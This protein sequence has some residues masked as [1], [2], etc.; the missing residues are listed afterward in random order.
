MPL[1]PE[2]IDNLR[3]VS[4]NLEYFNGSSW[5]QLNDQAGSPPPIGSIMIGM[6][7][8][9]PSNYLQ[10]NRATL[11][12]TTYSELWDYA[13]NNDLLASGTNPA[14]SEGNIIQFIDV[15]SSNFKL[16]DFRGLNPVV[17]GVNS[18]LQAGNGAS[19]QAGMAAYQKWM[20]QGHRHTI[21]LYTPVGS[22]D[23][24]A[25]STGS[26]GVGI[27]NMQYSD[28]II[29]DTVNGT[30]QVGGYTRGPGFGIGAYI[31][32]Q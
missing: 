19:L 21:H 18:F 10:L 20:M 7:L 1:Q 26:S 28:V 11:S 14:D 6:F 29:P 2:Q 13:Y 25:A 32:Y 30:P 3:V 9:T 24:V 4:G 8:S 27:Y 31:R 5:V 23:T 16:P 17:A 22:G 15:D 12:K